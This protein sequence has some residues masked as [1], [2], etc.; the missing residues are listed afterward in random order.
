MLG[1]ASINLVQLPT[2]C[3]SALDRTHPM[4]ALS[5]ADALRQI[6]EIVKPKPAEELR[7]V[8][9]LGAVLANDVLS[10]RDAP[11]FHKALMDGYA[12]RSGDLTG[13]GQTLTVLEEIKAGSLPTLFLEAGCASQI[14]TG[15]PLPDGADA[16]VKVEE[17]SRT[18]QQVTLL[19]EPVKPGTNMLRQADIL[20]QGDLALAAGTALTATRLAG[21]AEIGPATVTARTPCK[22]GVLATGDELVPIGASPAAGQIVNT[23]EILLTNRIVAAGHRA[24]GLGIAAD[25]LA[26]IEGKLRIGLEY[27]L[28]LLT[29]GVSAGVYDL[30]P[31]ALANLGVNRVFHK[32]EV[33]PGKPV[34]FGQ[35]QRP[36]GSIGY[37]FGL[38]GNPV[39]TLVCFEL[40]VKTAANCLLGLPDPLPKSVSGRLVNAGANHGE[41]PTYLPAE[42]TW[43][44]D[45]YQVRLV[46][47]QGSSDL[48]ATLEAN[49]MA[50][51]PK[52]A[53]NIPAGTAVEVFFWK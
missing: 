10:L 28:L 17:T 52:H 34:W 20:R 19:G 11:P 15:A 49:S 35:H 5:V 31:Q 39:S 23:N 14:M 21:I 16:V 42:T 29:G 8:D 13:P 3:Q 37:V 1:E 32:V 6:C 30:V 12:V 53:G 22:M 18:E 43:L 27:D 2:H 4:P 36:D 51:L 24:T 33:K 50:L 47:W 48:Q 7:L 44:D 46:K 45:H 41:R 26:D 40:F 9:A 38:P 25:N